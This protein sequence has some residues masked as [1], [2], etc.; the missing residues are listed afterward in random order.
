MHMYLCCFYIN[1]EIK[2]ELQNKNIYKKKLMCKKC[3]NS[4]SIDSTNHNKSLEIT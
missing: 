2:F 3:A 1:F 4:S